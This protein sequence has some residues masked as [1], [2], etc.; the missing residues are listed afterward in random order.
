[1]QTPSHQTPDRTR[2][3]VDLSA[4]VMSHPDH[5]SEI[6]GQSKAAIIS[7]C[8]VEALP[9]LLARADALKKRHTELN[10]AKKR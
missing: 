2:L 6:T 3:S 1:M 8:L 10:Q 9:E 5:I 4:V 7:A